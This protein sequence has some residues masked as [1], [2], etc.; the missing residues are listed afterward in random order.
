[1]GG[2][3]DLL[4]LLH[5]ARRRWQTVR[6]VARRWQELDR[7]LRAMERGAEQARARGAGVAMLRAVS[8]RSSAE[9]PERPK[10]SES[11]SRYWLDPG[12]DRVRVERSDAH[13]DFYSVRVGE[14]WWSYHPLVG[15]TS[16]DDD[17]SVRIGGTEELGPLLDPALVLGSLDFERIGE[18]QGAGRDGVVVR[19][20]PREL[21]DPYRQGHYLPDGADDFQLLVDAE[22]G[23]LLR[24]EARLDGEPF[25]ISEVV[26]VHFDET[27]PDEVFVFH[28]PPGEQVR[29]RRDLYAPPEGVSV[30]EAA[31]RAPFSVLAPRRLP[32]GG[33][34]SVLY[35]PG[36][37]RPAA[38]PGVLMNLK[39]P[40]GLHELRIIQQAEPLPDSLD[41]VE[42]E[43]D[44]EPV[45]VW[46]PTGRLNSEI[47]AKLQRQGTYARLTGNLDRTTLVEIAQSLHAAPPEIPLVDQ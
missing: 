40:T 13:G 4:E 17:L 19:A 2:L 35:T 16:N 24:L 45:F 27:L 22:R 12:R 5:G 44:G 26:E 43:G 11:I 14:R 37:D 39:D 7:G 10:V 8:P 36:R 47:E 1:M 21:E 32:E 9:D 46:E 3:G 31:R 33:K 23:I 29:S 38:E 20:T 18:R 34:L 25:M 15:A 41:W 28:P 30:E 6:L 42:V